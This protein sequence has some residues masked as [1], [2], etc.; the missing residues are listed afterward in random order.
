MD[1]IHAECLVIGSG[2]AGLTFA[3]KAAEFCEV[4]ILTKT[5]AETANTFWAQGGVAAVTDPDDS[6]EEHEADTLRAGDGLCHPEVVR[7]VVEEAPERIR[8]LAALGAPFDRRPDG[9][10]ELV[11]EGGH[12][13]KRILHVGDRTGEAIMQTLL[14]ACRAHA[15]IKIWENIFAVD[16]ITQH[17]LGRYVNRGHP[18]IECYGVYALDLATRKVVTILARYTVLATG[19]SGNVYAS[20]TN[21]PVATGDGV[22]MVYRAKGRVANMEF[23]QFHPTALYDPGV[24]PAFLIT[25]ALRGKGAYL[26]NS[27]S[28]QRFMH[29]YDERLELAPRDV[30]ARAI[31]NE[32]KHSGTPFVYLDATHLDAQELKRE[33][34]TIY[35][36]CLNK[37]L[38]IA[39][40]MIPVVPSAHYQCGG[41][42]T[43][44]YARTSIHRL[45]A[46][47]ECAHTGLHGAN[48]LASNSLIEGMVFAHRAALDIKLHGRD[49][50]S[51]DNIPDWNDTG[52]AN[53]EEWV[54]ISHN[55]TELQNIMSNYV[56]IVRT[57]LRLE[58][59]YRRIELIYRET[60][61]FYRRH[62]LSPELCELRNLIVVAYLIVKCAGIRK[63]SRGLHY[64]T[65]YPHKLP[66]AY[67][68]LL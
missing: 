47:G 61:A 49:V 20:T 17:H 23:Y 62:K 37:G 39:R 34:P 56:G 12:G 28:K 67:D 30:V 33:F 68:T 36:Y 64:N 8:E 27:Y 59:A 35:A 55:L 10:L 48:R 42:H 31:D 22:A 43:D 24:R 65:D 46:I 53:P 6:F 13:K 40:D 50:R 51:P 16:L 1:R 52:Y 32:L 21:P 66:V 38:D 15:R 58:R 4:I 54:L 45:Y 18:D 19:G 5:N 29:R 63:E 25:E 9:S 44:V 26:R 2:I 3:L 57:N 7:V 14:A 41:I 11:R 60:E